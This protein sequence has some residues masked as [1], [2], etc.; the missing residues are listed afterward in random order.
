MAGGSAAL[1]LQVAHPLVA[2][3][4][5]A[6]S[7]FVEDPLRRL[8]GTLGAV[9]TV[10]FGDTEQVQQ[11]VA[12]VAWRHEPVSG[13]LAISSGTFAAGTAYRADDPELDLWVFAT[14]VWTAI[15]VLETLG[16]GVSALERDAYYSDM[17]DFG[18][19]FGADPKAMP[20]DY[21]EL[22]GYVDRQV[23]EVLVVDE[24]ARTLARQILD[25]EPP[26]LPAPLRGL[27]GLLAAGLFP[28][29]LREAYGLSWRRRERVAFAGLAALTRLTLPAW[30]G[31]VR[32][33]PHY[34]TARRRTT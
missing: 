24:V 34:R 27:P 7:N 13:E 9:L 3:G 5:A 14:L 11:A 12:G 15:R 26:L 8:R 16:G 32:Y 19:L 18:R 28:D 6:H 2:A 30:P 20:G 21:A 33:W 23:R 25:P 10:T 1:L 29:P 17:R 4:V 31:V 22:A